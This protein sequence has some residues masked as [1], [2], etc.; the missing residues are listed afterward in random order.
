MQ[1]KENVAPNGKLADFERS[2]RKVASALVAALAV[3]MAGQYSGASSIASEVS[4]D[5][6]K[7]WTLKSPAH[8][9]AVA[10]FEACNVGGPEVTVRACL[11]RSASGQLAAELAEV[12]STSPTV[13]QAVPAPLRW[14]LP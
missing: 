3:F 10:E 12:T 9:A 6:L 1:S 7:A 2:A 4:S 8:A 5:R 14:F 13:Y 11:A